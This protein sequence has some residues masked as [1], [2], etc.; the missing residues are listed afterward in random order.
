MY[1]LYFNEKFVVVGIIIAILNY[2][3][4]KGIDSAMCSDFKKSVLTTLF[5]LPLA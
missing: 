2:I 4:Q 1:F 3:L 5:F